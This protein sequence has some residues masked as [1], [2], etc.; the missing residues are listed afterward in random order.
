MD[1]LLYG[2]FALDVLKVMHLTNIPIHEIART[3]FA[4]NLGILGALLVPRLVQ[5]K[6]RGGLIWL[7]LF[8][9]IVMTGIIFTGILLT[10]CLMVFVLARA[11]HRWSLRRGRSGL[12][13]LAAWIAV[14]ILYFPIFYL[15]FPPFEG[16][17]TVGEMVLF[18]GPAFVVLRSVHY[19]HMAC[20]DRIDPF[21]DEAFSRFLLYIVHFP[22]FWFGP[23]QKFRQFDNEVS[24]C[25]Q[26]IS[27]ENTIAGWKRIAIGVVKFI[28][29]FHVFNVPFFYE[30]NYYGP[31]SDAL[32]ANAS[33]SD[34]A[35]LWLMMYLFAL[36]ITLFISA[37]SDGVI[38][39]NLIMGI[40]V[41]ENSNWPLFARDILEFWRRWHIQAGVF[42][43]DEVF[44]PAG[45][46]RSRILGFFCV[47]AYSG[48]W[49]FPSITA[50][51]AFPLLQLVLFQA[52]QAWDAFWQ[53]HENKDDRIHAAGKRF[54]LHGT[55]L[56]GV[57]GMIFVFH[58]NV[59]SILFI[60][61]HFFGGSTMLPRMF[62]W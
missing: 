1:I 50:V 57:A 55:W 5:A 52:T 13:L 32:F 31:F 10:A 14:N 44:F 33:T 40:R 54:H 53:V 23:Y 39:M 29:I 41:P 51:L 20:K 24:T 4:I 9:L 46:R 27:R 60:H 8:C 2:V 25:K 42:L 62:G 30:Y 19:L 17:M 26:R 37:L 6:V 7:S 35:H 59:L 56:S 21:A 16:F 48:F 34:P 36:R 18:W 22:S 12:P 43:R 49:H 38:G 15:V 28:V 3:P 47:F 58:T 61:D 11:L 45:G